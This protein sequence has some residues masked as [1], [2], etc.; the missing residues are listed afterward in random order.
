M[1]VNNNP[2]QGIDVSPEEAK[3]VAVKT[4]R[5]PKNNGICVC[6]HSA[7]SHT[8]VVPPGYSKR[9]DSARV[10]GKPKC[11][12]SKHVCPCR[13]YEEV[14]TSTDSRPFRKVTTGAG[15]GHALVKGI[16][17]AMD[18]ER[19]IK[20]VWSK[21]LACVK[22]H[23][24]ATEVPLAPVAYDLLWVE[25]DDPTDMNVMICRNCRDIV[26]FE[27]AGIEEHRRPD[28]T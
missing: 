25:S 26:E 10:S 17:T 20:I 28:R 23:T 1:T 16:V 13:K 11:M 24:P 27:W 14:L 2:L 18:A 19:E 15:P 21:S 3:A 22:C 8:S 6:G 5:P 12:P 7:N 4:S 9:H